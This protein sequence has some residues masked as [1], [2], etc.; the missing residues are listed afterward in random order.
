LRP[1]KSFLSPSPSIAPRKAAGPPKSV[2]QYVV[3][4][5]RLHQAHDFGGA[6]GSGRLDGRGRRKDVRGAPLYQFLETRVRPVSFKPPR[7][8]KDQ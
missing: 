8:G 2:G 1:L 5:Q 4:F 7:L 6:Q 3:H